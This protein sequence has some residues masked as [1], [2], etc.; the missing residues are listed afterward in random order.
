MG[1]LENM[2]ASQTPSYDLLSQ[3]L[4]AINNDEL[5]FAQ[6]YQQ[7]QTLEQQAKG[8]ESDLFGD[9]YSAL[10]MIASTDED[11]RLISE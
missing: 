11:Q 7:V 6:K 4:E 8:V 10:K 2:Q 9:A 3:A 5:T 1:L